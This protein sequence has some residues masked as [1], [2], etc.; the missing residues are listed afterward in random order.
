M[1]LH[2]PYFKINTPPFINFNGPLKIGPVC[3]P[4]P[5]CN[6]G[7][8]GIDGPTGPSGKTGPTGP[9][10]PSIS[11]GT[12]N[13]F[14]Q[15]IYYNGTEWT[16][17]GDTITIGNNAGQ[18]NQGVNTTALGNN[19]GNNNQGDR[20][21]A[22]GYNAGNLNQDSYATAVG[23]NAGQTTQGGYSTAIG[24]SSGNLN[25]A[26]SSTSLGAF[27]GTQSQGQGAVAVGYSSG[28]LGQG[29]YSIAIGEYAGS[30]NQG[31]YSIAVGAF[32]GINSQPNKSIVLNSTGGVVNANIPGDFVVPG[33]NLS[34]APQ[35]LIYNPV[36]GCI[37]YGVPTSDERI[38]KN[39]IPYNIDDTEI[40][41]FKNIIVNKYNYTH[42][43]ENSKPRY[44]FVAQNIDA[45]F[46]DAVSN[47][48]GIIYNFYK[49]L[50]FSIEVLSNKTTSIPS[51]SIDVTDY[52]VN[53]KIIFTN[54]P[55]GPSLSSLLSVGDKI[56][57][58]LFDI[59]YYSVVTDINIVNNTFSVENVIFKSKYDLNVLNPT[60]AFVYGKEV[61]DLKG[62][63]KD[64][65]YAFHFAV[66]QKLYQKIEALE[67]SVSTLLSPPV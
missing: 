41:N 51:T 14:G 33:L 1:K 17:G 28:N 39:I 35:Q 20:S 61:N 36:T 57:Y 56:Q 44:G 59:I 32:S 38:K 22:V 5:I 9:T 58:K 7:Q 60:Q 67:T 55:S 10:G 50:D 3:R 47:N 30:V 15:Y 54:D 11:F 62:L 18:I 46:S 6:N 48:K 65:L 19:A 34:T 45:N 37:Y 21:T 8:M 26:F 2:N 16:I 63:D 4:I 13:T 52:L 25:Q 12:P 24:S 43:I 29:T 53:V 27:S 23:Y 66:T 49:N 40:L 64:A 31:Q 42:D